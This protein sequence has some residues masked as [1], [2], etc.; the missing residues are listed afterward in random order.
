M[1][2]AHLLNG[3]LWGAIIYGDELKGLAR[4]TSVTITNHDHISN[5]L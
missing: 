1:L 3:R 4:T 2:Q 5:S